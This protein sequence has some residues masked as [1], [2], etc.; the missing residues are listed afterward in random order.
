VIALVIVSAV[1][2]SS[3]SDEDSS[4]DGDSERFNPWKQNWTVYV[5]VTLPCVGGLVLANILS[6]CAKLENP[7][8][9]TLS[10]ECL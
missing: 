9:V 6:N 3:G 7:E 10:I 4:I 1:F 5:C 2:S 8:V